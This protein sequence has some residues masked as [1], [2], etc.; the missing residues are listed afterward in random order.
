MC[1]NDDEWNVMSLYMAEM[2]TR[3]GNTCCFFFQFLNPLFFFS[4]LL[5]ITISLCILPSLFLYHSPS[6]SLSVSLPFLH[7]WSFSLRQSQCLR[8]KKCP[9]KSKL[10]RKLFNHHYIQSKFS[11][12]DQFFFFLVFKETSLDP[13]HGNF[14]DQRT[15]FGKTYVC[16]QMGV[17]L[18][19]K[20]LWLCLVDFERSNL[21]LS[22]LQLGQQNNSNQVKRPALLSVSIIGFWTFLSS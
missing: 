2:K 13:K 19:S 6:M 15:P 22:G 3:M 16:V 17:R 8:R 14:R 11:K 21:N 4:L 5:S 18:A 1:W 7:L 10:A 12:S 20:T 9:W